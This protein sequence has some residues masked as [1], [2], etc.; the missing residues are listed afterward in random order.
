MHNPNVNQYSTAIRERG[1]QGAYASW[2]S[3]P[4]ERG[5][6]FGTRSKWFW[7]DV[8]NIINSRE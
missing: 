1:Q 7:P 8:L 5:R 3:F 2:G 6:H 4:L